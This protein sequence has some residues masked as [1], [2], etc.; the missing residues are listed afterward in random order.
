[1]D[2]KSGGASDNGISLVGSE[3]RGPGMA[4]KLNRG[5][6]NEDPSAEADCLRAQDEAE[7]LRVFCFSRNGKNRP[8]G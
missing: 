5:I 3:E 4:T 8:L 1:M 6:R 7:A 2:V